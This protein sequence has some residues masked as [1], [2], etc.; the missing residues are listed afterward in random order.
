M[1]LGIAHLA[2]P[3][4]T[5]LLQT[6]MGGFPA[7]LDFSQYAGW[8]LVIAMPLQDPLIV[9]LNLLTVLFDV[10]RMRQSAYSIVSRAP[11]RL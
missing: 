10:V 9:G 11:G 1:I 5:D 3:A 7:S 2:C 8:I 6:T 4:L